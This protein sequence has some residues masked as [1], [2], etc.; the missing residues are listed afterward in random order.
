MG[1]LAA[2]GFVCLTYAVEGK[3][4]ATKG[5]SMLIDIVSTVVN[6]LFAGASMI[7][8]FLGI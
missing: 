5:D 3:H 1:I 2:S 7:R 4:P 6:Y 8:G